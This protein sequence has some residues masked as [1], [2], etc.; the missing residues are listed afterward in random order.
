M[1]LQ[2]IINAPT[3]SSGWVPYTTTITAGI[4][5][6]PGAGAVSTSHYMLQGKLLH[7]SYI[8]SQTTAGSAGS[9]IYLFNIPS[10]FTADASVVPNVF[11]GVA[12]TIGIAYAHHLGSGYVH[13]QT[14][15]WDTSNYVIVANA[16]FI[17]S[18]NFGLS[19]SPLIYSANITIAIT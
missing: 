4:D 9:G 8:F 16:T 19:S 14:I 5:P 1:S 11:G 18:G 15:L 7:L 12:A 13:G 3:D 17:T 6:T 10:G 2:N